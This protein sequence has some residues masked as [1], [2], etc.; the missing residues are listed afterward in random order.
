[1]E[2]TLI[3]NNESHD[4]KVWLTRTAC[5]VLSEYID[6]FRPIATGLICLGKQTS[7]RVDFLYG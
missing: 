7:S 1:M 3:N 5:F 2:Y 6:V 4:C